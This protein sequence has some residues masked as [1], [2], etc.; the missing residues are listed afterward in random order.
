MALVG[1][2]LDDII[3]VKKVLHS[4]DA[5]SARPFLAIYN[6]PEGMTAAELKDVMSE[7]GRVTLVAIDGQEGVVRFAS[8]FDAAKAILKFDGAD[9][10]ETGEHIRIA[11]ES[12]ITFQ[13]DDLLGSS[14][15]SE[16]E[17]GRSLTAAS[18]G[19]RRRKLS[20]AESARLRRVLDDDLDSYWSGGGGGGHDRKRKENSLDQE[21]E[22]YWSKRPKRK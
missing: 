6:L 15:T 18:E 7:C 21:M 2:S 19:K 1:S 22:V 3:R 10:H 20:S 13:V 16:S 14:V 9:L 8:E 5:V 17:R 4:D 11:R 12:A